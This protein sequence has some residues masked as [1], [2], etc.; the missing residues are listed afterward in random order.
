[1]QAILDELGIE[2]S[3]TEDEEGPLKINTFHSL[4]HSFSI[5]IQEAPEKVN[6]A[7]LGHVGPKEETVRGKKSGPGGYGPPRKKLVE[8]SMAERDT[9]IKQ[10]SYPGLQP[11]QPPKTDRRNSVLV[12][13]PRGSAPADLARV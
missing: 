7:L 2:R 11:W 6:A 3:E 8:V 5:A 4:R 10:I 9:W 12:S 1:M 13:A